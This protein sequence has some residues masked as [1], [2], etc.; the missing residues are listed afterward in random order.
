M[1]LK[2]LLTE[3]K[4]YLII[5]IDHL[6]SV[7]RL[8]S[9]DLSHWLRKS[10]EA[11]EPDSAYQRLG[12]IVA[13]AVSLYDL[14][15]GENSAFQ[16]LDV[17][18]FPS[19][20]PAFRKLRVEDYLNTC[21]ARGELSGEVVDLLVKLTGG[22]PGFVEPL[23]MHLLRGQ[24]QIDLSEELIT[25]AV[26]EICAQAT[27]PVLRSLALQFW[28]DQ[29]LRDI[30][31]DLN[32]L[33]TVE[34]RSAVPDI[35]RFQLSGAVV[36]DRGPY[37]QSRKYQFRNGMTA[38]FLTLLHDYLRSD[39]SE[40]SKELSIA[41]ELAKLEA[42]KTNCLNAGSIW[43]WV[44][45][46]SKSWEVILRYKSPNICLYLTQHGLSS[47]WWFDT[48][49][50]KVSGPEPREPSPRSPKASA[51]NALDNISIAFSDDSDSIRAFVESDAETISISLPLCA[52][53]VTVI[54][55]ATVS[56]MDAG[57]RFTEFDLSH[58]IRFL[59][60]VKQVVPQLVL[61]ELGQRLIHELQTENQ[62]RQ[63]TG[64]RPSRRDRRED[65]KCIYLMPKGEA[66]IK[67]SGAIAIAAAEFPK[68]TIED[69]NN[70]CLEL[71]GEASNKPFE[72]K[73]AFI[74]N[75]MAKTF[76][77]D[78][79]ELV[80]HLESDAREFI[81]GSSQEGLK[82][83]FELFP[84]E[85]RYL[86][87]FAALS[88]QII[89]YSLP[90][91]VAHDFD[92][93]LRAL[94][95]DNGELRVLLVAS[96]AGGEIAQAKKEIRQVREH[97]QAGC[98]RI[99][100]KPP[101]FTEIPPEAATVERVEH[102][103]IQNRPYQLF[104]YSG[105]GRHY[106]EDPNASGLL[107]L[108]DDLEEVVT[109]RRLSRWLDGAG[110][111]LAYLSCC[112]GSAAS[113]GDGGPFE[114]Y[115]GTLDAVASAGVPN[116]VGFRWLVSDESAFYLADEFYRQLFVLQNEKNL[117]LAMLEA[118]R[119]VERRPDSF[120]AWASSMLITQYS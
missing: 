38:R 47:G 111:W 76:R 88:R 17:I 97:I 50:Q 5:F 72:E 54:V 22:E 28:G 71:V 114:R 37:N 87:T 112:Q 14:K 23:M 119:A 78:T 19:L 102:E 70:R 105:H 100:I 12:L 56:R 99:K 110:V 40:T 32:H 84:R 35:D 66:L 95:R 90:K 29:D 18:S 85:R 60:N 24:Q 43:T 21:M 27:N 20:D 98:E 79:P 58:W 4:G 86:A 15:H 101:L 64:A 62:A 48:S 11:A 80:R 75:Q 120:D 103:L 74:A 53:E 3:V 16:M 77:T 107:L 10:L 118:R 49:A 6:E 41:S 91:D 30:V 81:I 13:G 34:P 108:G 31:R 83:P 55:V 89:G 109:C 92:Y 45:H 25:T 8:F 104:H 57:R 39:G 82:I 36:V 26:D 52:R 33:T 96:E 51:Y 46:L 2:H 69:L 106:S 9:S 93:L 7:P 44:E 73:L 1:I 113:G 117:S 94:A 63:S 42:A 59:Q 65:T 68:D 115:V 116:I 67:E 61:T